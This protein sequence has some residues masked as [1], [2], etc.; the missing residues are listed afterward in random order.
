MKNSLF[1]VFILEGVEEL[2]AL[3]ASAL[4]PHLSCASLEEAS[5]GLE[6]VGLATVV[7]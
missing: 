5:F 3:F 7:V 6:N 1:P 2:L 4:S